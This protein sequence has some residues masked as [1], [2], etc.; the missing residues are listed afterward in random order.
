MRHAIFS[1]I[2]SNWEALERALEYLK[3]DRVDEYWVLGDTLGYGASPNE[4]FGW[5]IQNARV[6]VVGNHERAMID[7]AILD[8]F[9]S[10]ART[11][12]EWTAGILK[13]AFREKIRDLD[14]LHITTSATMAH[15]S[16]DNPQEFRYLFTFKDARP[17]FHSFET[18]LC[19][20]GHTHI[21][22]I[23]NEAAESVRYLRPGL[24]E[25]EPNER[26]ILN[27]G[28]V[29]QPR[30]HDPRLS[31]AIFDDKKW[32]F[33]LIR[34]EYDNQK[35]AAKIREAGLPEYLARRLL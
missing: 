31:F 21:P 17:S 32:T 1:D 27:P 29:G 16:P 30:D 23:I 2:H 6:T 22:S 8:W 5:M 11:A 7:P 19:F 28:S 20:V 26:Y 4:C 34:L 9:N 35:A 10:D 25:L 18:A 12:A 24:C 3:K 15:G 33:E 13:P 14:F